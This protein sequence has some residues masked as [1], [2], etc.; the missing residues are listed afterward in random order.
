MLS[1]TLKTEVREGRQLTRA[2]ARAWDRIKDRA[3][4][5]DE[6]ALLARFY[7]ETKSP[8][9][10]ETWNRKAAA[11]ALMNQWDTQL[12]FAAAFYAPGGSRADRSTPHGG[13]S[14][15]GWRA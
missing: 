5:S 9:H 1:L 3:E 8:S 11:D 2:E 13:T 15:F 4:L 10:D 14:D 12:D 7:G 6:I